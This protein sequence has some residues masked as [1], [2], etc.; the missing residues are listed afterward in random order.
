MKDLLPSMLIGGLCGLAIAALASML[1][2]HDDTD[3][4][5]G[6]SGL[7]LSTDHR[8]GCQYLGR[9][10]GGLTPR[11]DGTGKHLGCRQ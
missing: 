2:P 1:V 3:P 10:L 6:R 9:P 4:P 5:D 8:T 7:T 11:L